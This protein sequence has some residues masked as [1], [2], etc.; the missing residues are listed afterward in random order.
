MYA[1]IRHECFKKY[2]FLA[3]R[4]YDFTSYFIYMHFWVSY[5]TFRKSNYFKLS[6]FSKKSN[7]SNL[8]LLENKQVKSSKCFTKR[9]NY[10]AN[11]SG[12]KQIA[13]IM[14][15]ISQS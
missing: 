10:E 12:M 7:F 3:S 14:N 9:I 6:Y 5:V 1:Q 13:D 4:K 8:K 15:K 2:A 11:I